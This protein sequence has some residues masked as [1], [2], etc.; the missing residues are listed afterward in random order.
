MEVKMEAGIWREGEGRREQ[1]RKEERFE[2]VRD[3][4]TKEGMKGREEKKGG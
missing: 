2:T 4:G 3:E 1:Q